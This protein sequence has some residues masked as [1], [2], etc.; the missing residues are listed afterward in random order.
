LD[1]FEPLRFDLDTDAED[2]EEI[3]G[4]L[5]DELLPR[6][7]KLTIF[8]WVVWVH[9]RDHERLVNAGPDGVAVKTKSGSVKWSAHKAGTG[10]NKWVGRDRG[11]RELIKLGR[12]SSNSLLCRRQSLIGL[13][14]VPSLAGLG[15]RWST[16]AST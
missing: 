10:R 14:G 2:V 9:E 16:L 15:L 13:A 8:L 5:F 12:V 3:K 1:V 4:A 7:I 6:E 11:L